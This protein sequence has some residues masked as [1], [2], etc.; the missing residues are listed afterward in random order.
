MGPRRRGDDEGAGHRSTARGVH[1]TTLTV[2]TSLGTTNLQA[3]ARTARYA[4]LTAW[5][6]DNHATI[7][8]TAHHADDQA[9]TFLMRAARGS[10]LAGLAAIRPKRPLDHGILLLRPLLNWRRADLRALAQAWRLPF[11]DD[12]SNASDRHDRTRF[13]KLL[14]DTPWLDPALLARSAGYLFEAE[15]DLREIESWLLD[16]RSIAAATGVIAFDVTGLPR[17]L[18][19]RLARAGIAKVR[20]AATIG[21][22]VFTPATNIEPLLDALAA[23][24]SATQ[25]GVMVSPKGESWHFRP[26]PP[27]RGT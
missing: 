5:A 6:H 9:E 17:D 1:H 8:A 13:R 25:A 21:E 2:T 3:A 7:L 14:G 27:R 23:G 18:R 19:R 4:L 24:K 26:E 11:V 10:G 12:P 22:S 20:A 15:A 16:T